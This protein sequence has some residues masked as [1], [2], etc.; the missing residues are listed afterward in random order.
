MTQFQ[1]LPPA[2]DIRASKQRLQYCAEENL[3]KHAS[4]IISFA[5]G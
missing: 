4:L 5:I 3:L 1:Q 2:G